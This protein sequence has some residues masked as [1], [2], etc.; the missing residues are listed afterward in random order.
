MF[1]GKCIFSLLILFPSL[2][3]LDVS[4]EMFHKK[5]TCGFVG[6]KP[7]CCE[8]FR[9][10]ITEE[11]CH[12]CKPGYYKHNCS[13]QCPYPAYGEKCHQ[14]CNCD[15]S[16]CNFMNGCI[17]YDSTL[18]YITLTEYTKRPTQLLTDIFLQTKEA[19][20]M[21]FQTRKTN[22]LFYAVLFLSLMLVLLLIFYIG[23]TFY[24]KRTRHDN[25]NYS[26]RFNRSIDINSLI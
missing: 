12:E 1:G 21:D 15:K 22:E 26:V 17:I 23:V 8:G 4:S 16:S 14:K 11:T 24:Q 10:N 19:K 18:S 7:I 13:T 9:W 2:R 25:S 6:K 20:G 3:R 5:G